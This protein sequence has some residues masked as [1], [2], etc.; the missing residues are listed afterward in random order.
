MSPFSMVLIPTPFL[1]ISTASP[2]Y[3]GSEGLSRNRHGAFTMS[4]INT[5]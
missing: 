3:D 2:Q 5:I 4:T 1:L